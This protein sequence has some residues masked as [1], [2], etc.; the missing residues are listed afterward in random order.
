MGGHLCAVETLSLVEV[1]CPALITQFGTD[2]R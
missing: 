2:L 1:G